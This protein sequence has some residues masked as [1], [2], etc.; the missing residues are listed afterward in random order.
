MEKID[1][2]SPANIDPRI[3]EL[4][5]FKLK[6]GDQKR[7]EIIQAAIECMATIGFE[8][9]TYEAIAKLIGTRRAHV[10]YYFK[11]KTEIILSCIHYIVANYQQTSIAHIEKAK[12]GKQMLDHY[13]E[14]PFIWAKKHPDELAVMLL[15]YYLCNIRP[16][17]KE[18]H[19]QVRAGGVARITYILKN[20]L[21]LDESDEV[22]D[23]YAKNIISLISGA[24][25]DAATTNLRSLKQAEKDIK[26]FVSNILG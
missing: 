6:K 21:E 12:T 23:L 11:D 15:F 24:M 5:E 1:T 26:D 7:L 13:I 16:E 19:D 20:G 22:I 9:T 2:V 10:N 8:M 14:A 4:F 3:L 17:Y 25:M 18:L